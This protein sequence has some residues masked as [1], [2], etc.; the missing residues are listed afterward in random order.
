MKAWEVFQVHIGLSP[1]R[2]ITTLNPI[3]SMKVTG[4]VC[5]TDQSI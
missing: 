3:L 4:M 1:K 5:S 2:S